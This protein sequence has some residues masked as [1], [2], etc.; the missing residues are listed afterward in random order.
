MTNKTR[1]PLEPRLHVGMLVGAVV[2]HHQV[3]RD[4]SGEFR[5]QAAQEFQKLLM[6]VARV[7]LADDFALQNLQGS[8]Q[9]GGAI[10]LVIVSH[11]AQ[12]PLL[13]GQSGLGA[14][15]C[16]ELGLLVHAKNQGLVGRIQVQPHHIGEPRQEPR[17]T[18]ELEVVDPVRLQIVAAPNIADR[19]FA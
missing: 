19:G 4:I 17:I 9:T 14:V 8:E 6:T 2:V 13:H 10:T 3:Q 12:T 16:L 11:R 5:I 7:A 18:R 1:A 15:Q